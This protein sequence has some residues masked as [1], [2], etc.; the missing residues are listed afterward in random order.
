MI[1]RAGRAIIGVNDSWSNWQGHWVT[2]Q[3]LGGT[4]LIDYGNS[5]P[6]SDV[7]TV[8]SDGRVFIS[9]PPC[10]GSAR[11]RGYSVWAP[12]GVNI[13]TP[14]DQPA[15]ITVQEWE[16]EDD[17]G[18]SHAYSLKQ[19]GRLPFKSTATRTAGKIFP[20]AGATVTIDAYL[21]DAAQPVRVMLCNSAGAEVFGV[22]GSGS[23]VRLSYNV[24]TQGWY[25]VKVR[26]ANTTNIGQK[27]WVKAAYYAPATIDARA[28]ASWVPSSSRMADEDFT[29]QTKVEF[30]LGIQ[31]NPAHG[32]TQWKLTGIEGAKVNY[33]V[34]D[35]S[36]R[37]VLSGKVQP[38]DGSATATL[39][40][41]NLQAGIYQLEVQAENGA[42]RQPF[43][44]E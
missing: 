41:N 16:M 38:M 3:F 31:P 40:L 27:L 37:Q 43:V 14:I 23:S 36:G 35:V 6:M 29:A 8:A 25:Y 26:N 17:L 21:G 20:R 33:R 39:K 22:Q 19:G 13:N 30:E 42:K 18:D 28:T 24:P 11:R 1:E 15:D 9:T 4:R 32:Q 44:V 5:S 7:R 2:T 10:N 12:V 34:L